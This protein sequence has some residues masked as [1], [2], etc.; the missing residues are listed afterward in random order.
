MY[1]TASVKATGTDL[2]WGSYN[3]R[4]TKKK[5]KIFGMKRELNVKPE[6]SKEK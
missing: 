2:A 6:I 3:N 5:T 1:R 4:I